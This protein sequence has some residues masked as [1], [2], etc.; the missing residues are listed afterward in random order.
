M[1][2][3]MKSLPVRQ[4][5]VGFILQ[6]VRGERFISATAQKLPVTVLREQPVIRLH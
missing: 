4:K 1:K 6:R 3:A 5:A 2:K